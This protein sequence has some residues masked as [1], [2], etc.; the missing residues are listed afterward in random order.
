MASTETP[1]KP[2]GESTSYGAVKSSRGLTSDEAA[3]LLVVYGPNQLDGG[4]KESFLRILVKQMYNLI[5]GLSLVTAMICYYTGETP[6]S[7]F[8][9]SLVCTIWF[10]NSVGEYSGQD[11]GA[12]LQSMSPEV[13]DVLRDGLLQVIPVTELVPGDFVSIKMGDIVPADMVILESVDLATNEAALTGEPHDAAKRAEE[14]LTDGNLRTNMVYKS[15]SVVTGS[16]LGRV[17]AT[18]MRTEVGLIA[19]RLAPDE[20]APLNPLQQ[21]INTLATMIGTLSVCVIALGTVASF[22]TGYQEMPPV[23]GTQDSYCLAHHS[24]IRGLLMAISLIPHGLPL[25]VM[26]MLRVGSILMADRNAVVTRQS[27]VDTAGAI[28]VICTD[29]TGTLTEGKMAVKLFVGLLRDGH[30]GASVGQCMELACYPLHGL[31]PTGAIFLSSEL[32]ANRRQLLDQ[33]TPVEDVPGLMDL[34]DPS[35]DPSGAAALLARATAAACFLGCHSTRIARDHRTGAW[36]AMGSMSEAALKVAAHK[37]HVEEGSALACI[38]NSE[39]QR[40]AALEVPFS[41]KRKMSATVHC[42]PPG[43]SLG[44]IHFPENCTHAAIIKGAPDRLLENL[45]A[46]LE[47][48]T[49]PGTAEVL[50]MA[51]EGM[52]TEERNVIASQNDALARQALRSLLLAVRPL[53]REEVAELRAADGAEARLQ[54]LLSPGPLALLGLCGIFDPPRASV[55]PS[56]RMCHEAGIRV[57]MITGDQQPTALSIGKLIGIVGD[58][59]KHAQGARLCSDL[60]RSSGFVRQDSHRGHGAR[61]RGMSVHDE[62]TETDKH[63]KVYKDE[64]ELHKLTSETAIWSRAC[65]TDKVCIVES[66]TQESLCAMTG[67]GVNDAPALRRADIGVAMGIAGTSVAK[68]AA[69]IILMDDNFST[70]VAAVAEGR[71]IYGNVQKYVMF[72]LSVK[73]AECLCLLVAILANVP[74]PIHGVQQLINALCTH[75]IPPMALAW[76]DAESYSMKVPPREV[77]GDLVLNKVH[78]LTRWLPF[79]LCHMALVL[80]TTCTSVYMQ[81]G[82]VR[83]DHLIGSSVNGSVAS[84]MAACQFAGVIEEGGRFIPDNAPFHCRCSIWRSMLHSRPEIVDEWGN[85]PSQELSEMVVQRNSTPFAGKGMTNLLKECTDHMG[86]VRQC[87]ITEA[88]GAD[89]LPLLDPSVTCAALGAKTG[90]TSG[91]VAIHLGEILSLAT[92]RTDGFYGKARFSLAYTLVLCFNISILSILL[93]VPS[94]SELVGLVPLTSFQLLLSC[95]SPIALCVCCELMKVEYRRQLRVRNSL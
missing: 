23:C 63:E 66:L 17:L 15:T 75:M 93:Y 94:V 7:Y 70:V 83:V 13:C 69:D 19:K 79:V 55:P 18:G 86:I 40:E 81:T 38:L 2:T 10:L 57:V 12:A 80:T 84:G 28:Q 71:R 32:T 30:E 45:S 58:G 48:S 68:N 6:K 85:Y 62:K 41:S 16:G 20:S 3:R 61:P 44:S 34:A 24:I 29:K 8:L 76:E 59:D 33:G 50:V 35:T 31:D 1:F 26:V 95:L 82:F 37:G 54:V 78:L 47:V 4:Q 49:S 27:S 51:E 89:A 36:L 43:R 73:G 53:N 52:T 14:L 90:Q 87:W 74:A 88:I 11:P 60:H 5:F 65:P 42:L 39:H 77:K 64:D 25:V 9:V 56:I 92:F 21:S 72:S 46:V 22:L 67:D 91:Y